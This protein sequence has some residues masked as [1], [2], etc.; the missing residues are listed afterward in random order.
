MRIVRET[1]ASR[2]PLATFDGLC[3]PIWV[4]GGRGRFSR[5]AMGSVP[6]PALALIGL[7]LVAVLVEVF[8][9]ADGLVR[10]DLIGLARISPP[11]GFRPL[12]QCRLSAG[13]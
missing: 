13:E 3:V 8:V 7:E 6:L 9:E 4:R 10:K 12:G 2:S 1:G 11:H 5:G